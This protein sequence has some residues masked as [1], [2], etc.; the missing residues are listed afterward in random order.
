MERLYAVRSDP[1][2]DPSYLEPR[3]DRLVGGVIPQCIAGRN[4]AAQLGGEGNLWR[5][6]LVARAV[7]GSCRISCRTS[8]ADRSWPLRDCLARVGPRAVARVAD[9]LWGDPRRSLP[10]V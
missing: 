1:G 5:E 2:D 9:R 4:D 6:A 7:K 8:V 10:I 3:L